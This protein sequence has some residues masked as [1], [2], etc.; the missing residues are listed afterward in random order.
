MSITKHEVHE[1]IFQSIA[2]T[3][4]AQYSRTVVGRE[5]TN[6]VSPPQSVPGSSQVT[7]RT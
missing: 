5:L 3:N 1:D 6:P 7:R 2:T 4:I